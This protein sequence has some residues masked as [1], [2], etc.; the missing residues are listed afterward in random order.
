MGVDFRMKRILVFWSDGQVEECDVIGCVEESLIVAKIGEEIEEA[1][2]LKDFNDR[3][4][5][6]LQN[7]CSK[8][9]S[10]SPTLKIIES[11]MVKDVLCGPVLAVGVDDEEYIGLNEL[12]VK[13]VKERVKTAEISFPTPFLVIM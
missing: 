1:F 3:K 2:L 7:E 10:E 9:K 12:Q 13:Y 11:G 4:I 5:A 6:F 8:L